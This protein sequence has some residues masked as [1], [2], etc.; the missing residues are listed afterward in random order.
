V[1]EILYYVSQEKLTMGMES[2]EETRLNKELGEAEAK[3]IRISETYQRW[4]EGR[5][6]IIDACRQFASA[7]KKWRAIKDT[8]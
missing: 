1:V 4:K 3:K 2:S 5:S 7:I 6:Q 8:T